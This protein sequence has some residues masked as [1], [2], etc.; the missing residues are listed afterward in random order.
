MQYEKLPQVDEVEI[1]ETQPKKTDK[2][3]LVLLKFYSA[4]VLFMLGCWGFYQGLLWL[5]GKNQA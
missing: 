2:P 3:L 4:F 1:Q 5:N